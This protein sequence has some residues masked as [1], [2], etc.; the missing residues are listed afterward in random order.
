M[1]ADD[2]SHS[3]TL[4]YQ[5][6]PWADNENNIWLASTI[7]IH[8]NLE[9]FVFPSKME[10]EKKAQII[11]LIGKKLLQSDKLKSPI[12]IRSEEIGPLQKHYLVEHFL[13][14]QSFQ[15]A[16]SGEAFILDE[17]GRFLTTLNVGNHIQFELIDC[18]G[19]L[20]SAWNHIVK[21]ESELGSEFNFSFTPK[22]G[23]LTSDTMHCGTGFILKI[24]LQPSALIHSG[25]I[26]ETLK[27]IKMEGIYLTGLQGDPNEIIGD[28]YTVMNEYAL[29]LTEEN[30]ISTVRLF[31]T[32][33]LVEESTAR[34][35]LR[36]EENPLV[37]DKVSRAFG[38]LIHSYQIGTIE[39]LNAISLLKLG[40]D[41][42]WLEGVTPKELNR[43]FFDC[44]RAHLLAKFEHD[45]PHDKLPHKRA[46]FIHT[47]LAK[48]KLKI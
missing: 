35:R 26:E 38:V 46:E 33:L 9:K 7:N 34:S 17:S 2:Q 6:K 36:K 30:I 42:G 43:L 32:K 28:I 12:L 40:A 10:K 29:G 45:I 16:H 8:R 25:Q 41:L 22:F 18:K 14:S 3:Q 4:L 15:Q 13:S 20:E 48:A 21:I 37:M 19:E 27:R 44:R 11:F 1:Q 31:T 24:F 23:F 5:N 39:S 47:T